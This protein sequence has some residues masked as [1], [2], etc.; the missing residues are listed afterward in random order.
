MWRE[1]QQLNRNVTTATKL[2]FVNFKR[3]R[4]EIFES[5]RSRAVSLG[6]TVNVFCAEQQDTLETDSEKY[7]RNKR[8]LM[9]QKRV[10]EEAIV[11][12]QRDIEQNSMELQKK[13]QQNGKK[14]K[15]LEAKMHSVI[16]VITQALLLD[17]DKDIR[18][19]IQSM[20][21]IIGELDFSPIVCISKFDAGKGQQL[22]DEARNVLRVPKTDIFLIDANL[23]DK[24]KQ[25]DVDKLVFEVLHKAV[26]WG[27]QFIDNEMAVKEEDEEYENA[28]GK[29][30]E[31]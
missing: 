10:E 23:D 7:E 31:L 17:Q 11:R 5:I 16:F 24:K 30:E 26:T 8:D 18:K 14:K 1:I 12:L 13:Q 6:K 3:K 25:F 9:E 27:S 28:N 4:E 20:F 2:E 19:S 22:I 15:G 21:Q 29:R